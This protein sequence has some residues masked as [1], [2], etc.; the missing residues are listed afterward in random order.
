[1]IYRVSPFAHFGSSALTNCGNVF[2]IHQT[3]VEAQVCALTIDKSERKRERE[4][5]KKTEKEREKGGGG[6]GARE[7]MLFANRLKLVS[8]DKI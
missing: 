8:N 5:E 2:V 7:R 1:M 3:P 6:R 4:R